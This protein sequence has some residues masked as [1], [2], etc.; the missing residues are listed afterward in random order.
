M[1]TF[2]IWFVVGAFVG[3]VGGSLY[4]THA[5]AAK[6][7]R[8][9][10][11]RASIEEWANEPRPAPNKCNFSEPNEPIYHGPCTWAGQPLR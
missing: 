2:L 11:A 9:E 7:W 5:P 1:K 6:E 10:Q 4:N 8:A 3:L